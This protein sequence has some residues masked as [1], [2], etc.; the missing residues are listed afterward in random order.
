MP[1]KYDK[2]NKEKCEVNIC[3]AFSMFQ[4]LFHIFYT[5]SLSAVYEL[6]L[7]LFS[8]YK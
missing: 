2:R 8:F 4:A 7:L 1:L 6:D 3:G 5:K